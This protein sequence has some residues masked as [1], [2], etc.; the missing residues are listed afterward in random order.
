MKRALSTTKHVYLPAGI[1]GHFDYVEAHSNGI[2][3]RVYTPVGKKQH[4]R[5]ALEVLCCH[6]L[7]PPKSF[8]RVCQD[9]PYR[10]NLYISITD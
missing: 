8:H 10:E 2:L 9:S 6:H 1:C 7:N 4:G 5:F 3:V